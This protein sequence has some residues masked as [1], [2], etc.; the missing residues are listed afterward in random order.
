MDSSLDEKDIQILRR[1]EQ[2][3]EVNLEE[4]SEELGISKS[5]IH[6]RLKKLKEDGV[7]TRAMAE[8]D[9]EVFGLN[10][11]MITDVMV[12]HEEGYAEETG[13]KIAA[14]KGVI[15]VYYTMGDVDFMVISRVQNRDQ[16]NRLIDEIVAIDGVNETSSTFVMDEI[17][18]NH[19]VVSALSEEMVHNVLE[20]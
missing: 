4:L 13:S 2:N 11:M 18:D 3:Y 19:E 9:P 10:M 16:L 5:T 14:I 20:Q 6:Y 15:K 1:V 12:S 8:V 17:K 7:I